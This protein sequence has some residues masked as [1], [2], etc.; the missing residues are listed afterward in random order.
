MFGIGRFAAVDFLRR[1][2]I[3]HRPERCVW[4][5]DHITPTSD[6]IRSM[7][8]REELLILFGVFVCV[9]VCCQQQRADPWAM[10]EKRMLRH[11]LDDIVLNLETERFREMQ[12]DRDRDHVYTTLP[13]TIR[14]TIN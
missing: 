12:H 13:K 4:P 3:G 9:S 11:T 2:I 14:E 1:Q 8:Y 7:T 6:P 10:W 5:Q